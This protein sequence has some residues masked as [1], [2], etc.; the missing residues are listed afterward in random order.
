MPELGFVGF[1]LGFANPR[2]E[3]RQ[4]MGVKIHVKPIIRPT[5]RVQRTSMDSIEPAAAARG[6]LPSPSRRCGNGAGVSRLLF[7]LRRLHFSSLPNIFISRYGLT[8]AI[9][10]LLL[11]LIV[12]S[13]TS[14]S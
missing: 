11:N 12:L 1:R 2:F 10:A 6:A 7:L 9:D 14:L 3:L 4:L 8:V 13:V 5:A